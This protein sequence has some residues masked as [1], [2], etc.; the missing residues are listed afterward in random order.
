MS[1]KYPKYLWYPLNVSV[2][3]RGKAI[4]LDCGILHLQ[5]LSSAE[6][7]TSSALSSTE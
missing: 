1:F 5:Q 7:Q 2:P 4:E 6:L 3:P